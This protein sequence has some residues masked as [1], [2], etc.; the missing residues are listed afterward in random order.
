MYVGTSAEEEGWLSAFSASL[1]SQAFSRASGSGVSI[2][3]IES[4]RF[5]KKKKTTTTTK[6][7]T[8]LG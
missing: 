4:L 8:F 2:G 7:T 1:S 5:K 6:D 3:K